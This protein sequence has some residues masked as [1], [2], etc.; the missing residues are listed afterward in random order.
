MSRRLPA[1]LFG[2]LTVF[3]L[4]AAALAPVA[5]ASSRPNVTLGTGVDGT[6]VT[7]VATVNR[8]PRHLVGCTYVVDRSAANVC[9]SATKA[10]KKASR[11]SF[12]LTGVGVG[13][14]TVLVTVGLS[15]HRTASDTATFTIANTVTDTDGDGVADSADNCPKMAN[16]NQANHYGSA[17]GDACEDTDGDGTLDVAEANICVSVDGVV[18]LF[19]GRHD[20]LVL[21]RCEHQWRPQCRDRR[22]RHCVRPGV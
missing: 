22:W 5:A 18:I 12:T 9:G 8:A 7:V 21:Q 17:K 2:A 10:G 1:A 11:Y 4:I 6:T 15:H 3:A 13:T 14:H 20:C 19:A 16:P